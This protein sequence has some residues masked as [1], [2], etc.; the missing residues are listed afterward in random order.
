M[1]RLYKSLTLLLLVITM[2]LIPNT[3]KK[4]FLPF[5]EYDLSLHIILVFFL[6]VASIIVLTAENLSL[7]EIIFF[8]FYTITSCGALLSEQ[9]E[10]SVI[11]CELMS[12]SSFFIIAAG[13][14]SGESSVRYAST[15]LFSGSI[16]LIGL[17][18][19]NSSLIM[20]ALLIN[21]ACF[22]FSFW[23]V[24]A[25]PT[26]S[27]HGTTYLSLFTTKISF[28]VM[29]LHTYESFQYYQNLM[30][31][32]G[33][34]TIIYSIIFS[35][36]EKNIRRFMTYSVVGQM[37]M[38]IMA[39]A[40]LNRSENAIPLLMLNI[41]PSIIYQSLLFVVA[42]SIILLTKSVSF[43]KASKF[44][45]I[46]GM[47]A[48]I[49]VFT[50]AGFPGT[51]G[52]IAK[53]YIFTEIKA[54]NNNFATYS[55]KILHLLIYLSTGLKFLYYMFTCNGKTKINASML[56]L[57]LACIV[58]GN[59]YLFIYNQPL[60]FNAIYNQYNIWLQCT[61]LF[62]LTLLFISTNRLFLPRI[63]FSMDI[64][65]IFRAF[66][67]YYVSLLNKSINSLNQKLIKTLQS[68]T[69]LITTS[70]FNFTNRFI[71]YDSIS[72]VSTTSIVVITI[73][74]MLLCLNH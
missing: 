17:S 18:I 10:S 11:F 6:I 8:I 7:S 65:W 55:F 63:N 57:A 68:L 45:S 39:G 4:W 71:I 46:E 72:L 15:H 29:L 3:T 2:V 38:L 20:I 60:I 53:S 23:M 25:Y 74:L 37:G 26:A 32:L 49:A 59:P 36:L 44:L 58:I 54:N 34:F 31:L 70:Y 35:A 47:C 12:I 56:I 73:L 64:D 52:F 48:A 30:I 13:Y 40:L 43:N 67:P 21:C 42:N 51:A 66:I 1:K 69:K 62:F 33:G 50:M 5:I 9:I 24:D 14:K 28:L 19:H 16:L 27:L 41:I 22:P 61:V